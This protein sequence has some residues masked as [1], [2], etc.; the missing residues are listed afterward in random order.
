VNIN[1]GDVLRIID[2]V[3]GEVTDTSEIQ[4]VV[5]SVTLK[6]R[7]PG[8]TNPIPAG[9]RFE[10]YLE[11]AIVPHEQ[12]NEQLLSLI[13]DRV[14]YERKVDYSAGDTDG[15]FV[16]TTNELKD[17]QVTSWAAE[18]VEEGDYVL[19]D[20][21]G[22][23]YLSNEFGVRPLGDQS[24]SERGPGLPYIPGLP[25]DLD[26]NRGFYRVEG[27]TGDV[28]EVNGSSRFSDGSKFGDAGAEYVVLPTVNDGAEGQQDLRV[29][30]AAVAGS[31]VA[32]GSNNSVEPFGYRVIRVNP[33][34]SR[35]TVEL[36][37]FMRERMLSWI[38]ALNAVYR[39]G[40]DYYAFQKDDHILSIGSNTDPTSGSGVM[41]NV[42]AIILR[43]LVDAQPFA[44]NSQCLS[45]LDRRFWIL[46]SRLDSLPVGGPDFYTQFATDGEG[47]R[48]VL[49]DLIEEVLNLDDRIR[50]QRYS[51]ISFRSNRTNGSA[52]RVLR[53]ENNLSSRIRKQREQMSRAKSLKE[54]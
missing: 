25:S 23:L 10:V 16:G 54:S 17:T 18:G 47:Q 27:V 13:T 51:W 43:G 52:Q 30:E 14:V 15:G 34:F 29:T 32:R 35:D 24:V 39:Q 53:A 20:P 28:L 36:V 4:K 38:E 12:S 45:V 46:D 9:A 21:A 42:A 48:P 7:R 11:Q 33:V 50:D 26:D 6:L 44:N 1:S 31:F 41:H 3:S 22:V 8:L 19:V 40:G 2:P 37:L 5:N 49:P